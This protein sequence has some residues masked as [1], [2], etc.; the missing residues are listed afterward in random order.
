MLAG[1]EVGVRI[2]YIFFFNRS[3]RLGSHF[4]LLARHK[5]ASHFAKWRVLT[6]NVCFVSYM[7][8]AEKAL[9]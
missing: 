6:M 4:V 9:T 1:L 8:E 3:V 5:Y 7:T 2:M